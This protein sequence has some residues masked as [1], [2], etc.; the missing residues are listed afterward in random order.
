[1]RKPLACCLA[2]LAALG[3]SATVAAAPI[4]GAAAEAYQLYRLSGL[5]AP[6][7]LALEAAARLGAPS[8]PCVQRRSQALVERFDT[9]VTAALAE[10]PSARRRA[11]I[12][13]FEAPLGQR[14]AAA[15][16]RAAGAESTAAPDPGAQALFEDYLASSG[17]LASLADVMAVPRV[18]AL[19]RDAEV[20]PVDAAP[21]DT[22]AVE[23]APVDTAAVR[24]PL[25]R[26]RAAQLAAQYVGVEPD[27]VAEI[28][29]TL[30][31]D[32]YRELESL[33]DEAAGAVLQEGLREP[34]GASSACA[35]PGDGSV[36]R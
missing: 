2:L 18:G 33:V 8:G 7:V 29:R 11:L 35:R 16:A 25:Q 4:Q 26:H 30:G 17:Q 12:G 36:G 14:L 5:R 6:R 23:T 32:G 28:V 20:A 22:A 34:Q 24:A 27:G 13:W 1:M 31:S 3:S 10:L 21:V 19:L 9:A 15:N